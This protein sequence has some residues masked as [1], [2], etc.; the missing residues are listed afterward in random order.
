MHNQHAG[1]SQL[2]AAS[3][4]THHR[5]TAAGHPDRRG[6]Q[7]WSA[8]PPTPPVANPS[9]LAIGPLARR[10]HPAGRPSSTPRPLID[11]RPPHP[12]MP[13]PSSSG[14]D[15]P[16]IGPMADHPT[17]PQSTISP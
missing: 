6:P 12:N 3:H 8:A 13:A 2:L 9:L 1:L 17:A 14:P 11:P 15:R 10:H 5:P 7:R 16:P 4:P